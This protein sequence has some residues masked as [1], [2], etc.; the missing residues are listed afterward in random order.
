MCRNRSQ[1]HVSPGMGRSVKPVAGRACRP[2]R[3]VAAPSRS[4][5]VP[6]AARELSGRCGGRVFSPQFREQREVPIPGKERFDSMGHTDRRYPR[7]MDEP[8]EDPGAPDEALQYLGEVLGRPY[9]PQLR[10]GDPGRELTPGLL[11]ASGVLP[12]DARVGHDAVEL[13]AARPGNPQTLLPSA[14]PRTI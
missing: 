10:G 5:R 14:S 3:T 6:A 2:T 9:Q 13:V 7:I 1:V 12:P 8:S 11:R 4:F